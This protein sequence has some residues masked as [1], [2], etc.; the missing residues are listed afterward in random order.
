[1]TITPFTISISDAQIADLKER[2]AMTRWPDMP[3]KS[4]DRGQA[5]H[6]VKALADQWAHDFDWRVVEAELNHLPQF[7]TKIDGQT[8]HFLHVKSPRPNALPLLL[9]HGWPSTP[10]EYA[11]LII[12]LTEPE[13]GQA[14]DLVI[15]SIPGFGFSGPV[16]EPGWDS[17]RIAKAFDSLMKT[18][19]YERYGYQGGD[20]GAGIGREL[21]ILAPDGVVGIHLQQIFAFP[22]GA[23][24]EMDKL[25]P[26]EMGGFAILENFSKYASYNDAQQKRPLTLGYGLADSPVGLLGW[27]AELYFGFEGERAARVDRHRYITSIAIFWFTNTGASATNIY[28]E[29]AQTGAG[30]REKMNSVPTG[31]AVFPEDF[32]SVRSFAERANNI[33][34]WSEMERGGHFAALDEPYLLADDI[35]AFFSKLV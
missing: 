29:D 25:T 3:S 34:H 12:P 5:L 8:I 13:N 1:M 20:V 11:D 26:F 27:N 21:G 2:L 9:A 10:F 17:A 28:Y 31:V 19:G 15:P 7:I 35:R 6:L 33:V 18:L 30:Y 24:E 22:T 23:E 4:F 32:R 16:T 14:F